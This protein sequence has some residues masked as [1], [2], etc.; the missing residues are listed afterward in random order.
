MLK[1]FR[2]FLILPCLAIAFGCHGS[3]SR[4]RGQVLTA[5]LPLHLE[6][7]LDAAV[8]E[9]CEIPK[10]IRPAVEWR[11]DQDQPG[12]KT[13][14]PFRRETKPLQL[15]RI[16]DALRVTMTK[17]SRSQYGSRY[18]HVYTDL[19]DWNRDD[20]GFVM[21]RA[22][23]TDDGTWI[24]LGFNLRDK[25]GDDF[26]TQR[27]FL[28]TGDNVN[29]VA[30]GEVHTYLL[31]MTYYWPEGWDGRWK[32]LGLEVGHGDVEPDDSAKGPT[33]CDILSVSV[34]PKEMDYTKSPVGRSVE[35]WGDAARRTLYSH[36]P[37][38]L[39]F[40]VKV[41]EYGRMDFGFGLLKKNVPVKFRVS[42][43]DEQTGTQTL[44]EGICSDEKPLPVHSVDLSG[45]AGKTIAL[46]LETEAGE[47][48]NVAFW[49]AP[50]LSG[51]RVT[52]RPNIIFYIIDG[53]AA[54]FMSVYGYNRRT[55]PNLER[56]AAEGAVF[57][58][59]YSNSSWTKTSVPSFMTSLQSSVLGGFKSESD[60]LPEQAVPMAERM[61]TAGYITEVLTS[62]P[63]CGR[64]SGLDRG[65]DFIRD[66]GMEEEIIASTDLHR[67]FWGFR[68]AYPGEPYWVHFQ[69]T[70][71]HSPWKPMAPFVGLFASLEERRVFNEMLDKMKNIIGQSDRARLEK[72]GIDPTTYSHIARKL[73]DESMAHQDSAIGKLVERLKERGEWA[74]TLLVVAADH[75]HESAA[76]P[77]FD[78]MPPKWGTPILAAQVSRIPMIFV[79]AGKIPPGQRLSQPVSMIDMLPTVLDL[80]GL[81]APEIAQGQSLSPLLL[82][83]PGWKQR[84]VIFDEVNTV[85]KSFYGSVEVI[86][87]R[88]GA[89]LR[90]DTRPDEEKPKPELRWPAP[91]LLFDVWEDPYSLKSLHEE[92]PDLVEKYSKMLD[93]IWKD[94]QALA[95][96]FSRS[97]QVP[98]TPDQ[99]EALRSLGYLR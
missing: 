58:R 76:L 7:H 96:Q 29:L 51:G 22:R 27:R 32:E 95:Q 5:E 47:G 71:V 67:E 88:W 3:G 9:G 99:I 92:R 20:W 19:L 98:L 10:D 54:D 82:G 64:M 80:A 52:D 84:P 34:I 6:D 78:P 91:L 85:G 46:I 73:Y 35:S 83:K 26:M 44:F 24:E 56:L 48:R 68:E 2:A 8:I 25:P 60:P 61:H 90:L 4:S 12:W 11:F 93:R 49:S 1:V 15:A 23:T 77:L 45:L 33:I 37:G 94:H 40:P 38:K 28:F 55:T 74:R 21:V 30:D 57:E 97:G 79:W 41:P 69:P 39:E 36:V 59:A 18:G 50:T 62:N 81:P 14:V 86:D 87:G 43:R 72:A 70:D 42:A 63:Y 53:G 75:S 17:E 65:V 89:A 31:R 13:A 66:A 16:G